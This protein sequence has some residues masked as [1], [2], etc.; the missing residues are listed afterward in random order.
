MEILEASHQ[1]LP[2]VELAQGS[3]YLFGYLMTQAARAH[4]S[5]VAF[6]NSKLTPTGEK[7]TCRVGFAPLYVWSKSGSKMIEKYI[8]ICLAKQIPISM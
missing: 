3:D 4:R 6:T 7:M 1:L 8:A 5:K 2:D